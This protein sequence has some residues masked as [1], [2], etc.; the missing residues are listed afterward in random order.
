M[1]R[2]EWRGCLYW[3]DLQ[4]QAHEKEVERD[5]KRKEER[6]KEYKRWRSRKNKTDVKGGSSRLCRGMGFES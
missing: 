1:L 4:G 3:V 2:G 6:R 5:G